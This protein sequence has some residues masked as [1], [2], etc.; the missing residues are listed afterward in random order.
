[1]IKDK[2]ETESGVQMVEGLG[3]MPSIFTVCPS[4]V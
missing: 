1:M 2:T 3:A 4:G